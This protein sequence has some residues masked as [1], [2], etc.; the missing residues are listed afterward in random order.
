MKKT[1]SWFFVFLLIAL[2]LIFTVITVLFSSP[3]TSLKLVNLLVPELGAQKLD[4]EIDVS[5]NPQGSIPYLKPQIEVSSLEF[6]SPEAEFKV[7][8]ILWDVSVSGGGDSILFKQAIIT[9]LE[10]LKDKPKTEPI[11]DFNLV[12]FMGQIQAFA[13]FD[14]NLQNTQLK[15]DN[16]II[17]FDLALSH[18]VGQDDLA[19]S[20]VYRDFP[21]D[22]VLKNVWSSKPSK[23]TSQL[24]FD[25]GQVVQATVKLKNED[26]K[27][28]IDL[29][30]QLSISHSKFESLLPKNLL[31]QGLLQS[32]GLKSISGTAQ[33][34]IEGKVAANNLDFPQ[35]ELIIT[36]D[37]SSAVS[38]LLQSPEKTTGQTDLAEPQFQVK[39]SKPLIVQWHNGIKMEQG[40]LQLNIDAGPLSVVTQLSAGQCSLLHCPIDS[41][42]HIKPFVVDDAAV[43]SL[44]GVLDRLAPGAQL[45]ADLPKEQLRA[46]FN[47]LAYKGQLE[48]QD[49]R[50][51][52]AGKVDAAL[53]DILF[54]AGANRSSLG[55]AQ[56]EPQDREFGGL[57]VADLNLQLS[58]FDLKVGTVDGS[59]EI[60]LL[61]A[62]VLSEVTGFRTAAMPI[63]VDGALK[64]NDLSFEMSGGKYT[65]KGSYQLQNVNWQWQKISQPSLQSLGD[66]SIRNGDVE[67]SGI[68]NTD[69][70]VHLLS[71]SAEHSLNKHSGL[72]KTDIKLAEL[73]DSPLKQ[74]FTHWPYD[75]DLIAGNINLAANAHWNEEPKLNYSLFV[76]ASLEGLTVHDG[77][78]VGQGISTDF[79]LGITDGKL[80]GVQEIPFTINKLDIGLP[81]NN[82]AASVKLESW[83]SIVLQQFSA[84][85]LQGRVQGGVWHLHGEEGVFS[86]DSP[87]L[88]DIET[89]NVEELLKQA[90]YTDLEATAIVSGSL[91]VSLI[92][93]QLQ[94]IDG[95]LNSAQPGVIKY[96]GL[97]ES[98]NQLMG[99]V[100][101]A[102]SNYHYDS[103]NS[104]VTYGK[105]GDLE[106]GVRLLG[107]N[108]D[109]NNGQ[110]I[111]LNLNISD[112]IPSLMKSLQ[113][114]RLIT[115]TIEQGLN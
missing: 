9:L 104:T 15:K 12:E 101:E 35:H 18:K 26:S 115:D 40:G 72:L 36:A 69:L 50:L 46:Q 45:L 98:G 103:L 4:Y 65:V 71:Y 76:K 47:G 17:N 64:L 60:Q 91:P 49:N 66:I 39:V 8:T 28:P 14:L 99:L 75:F 3:S 51:Q 78:I 95:T 83:D 113:A 43:T 6:A 2:S 48:W 16:E 32:V 108:P 44:R 59:L 38:V 13:E 25:L 86:S 1:L 62:M 68:I 102:L 5:L 114:S 55:T 19:L 107:V 29:T 94:I 20:S 106:L 54:S 112:N 73:G 109:M 41:S 67:A 10:P 81:I 31:P 58:S 88:L 22:V 79:G 96:Q 34:E 21:L 105:N 89:L 23:L 80:S 110:R 11:I 87:W 100:S 111:N 61:N 93:N 37:T 30:A 84:D 53:S 63:N 57:T 56:G 97:G 7:S 74:Q 70:G 27:A 92:A 24:D 33:I 52:A 82:I 90:D 85:L 77:N 42:L